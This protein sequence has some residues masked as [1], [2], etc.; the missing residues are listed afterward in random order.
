[1]TLTMLRPTWRSLRHA[2][3]FTITATLTLVVGIATIVAIFALIDG[4]LLRPLPY[5]RAEELVAAWHDLRGGSLLRTDQTGGTYF[6]Y[7]RFAHSIQGIGAYQ[8]GAANVSAVGGDAEPRRVGTTWISASILPVLAI[9]PMLGRGFTDDEDRPNGADAAI[10]GE[11]LWRSQY[12]A[13]PG[14]L[15]RSIQVNGRSRRIVGVM[16]RG[17]RFPSSETQVWLPLQLVPNDVEGFSYDAI[18]RLKPGMSVLAAQRDFAAVLPRVVEVSPMLAPGVSTQMLFDQAKPVP[19]LIPLKEDIT[20]GVAKT[21]WLVGAGACVLLLVAC[22]NVTNLV[23]VRADARQRE[24]AVREALGAGRVRV[25]AYLL[26]ESAMIATFAGVVAVGLAALAIHVVASTGPTEI[27]RLAEVRIDITT[28]AFAIGIAIM[29]AVLCSVIP[30][31]RVGRAHLADALRDAGRGATA[32]RLQLRLRHSLVALQMALALVALAAS[33]LLVR[34]FQRLNAIRPGFNPGSVL[35]LWVSLPTARYPNDTVVVAFYSR[36]LDRV[37]GLPGVRAASI[38][39]RVPLVDHGRNQNPFYPEDDPSFER[40]IPPVQLYATVDGEYFRAM[41]IPLLAGRTF[42]RL[43]TQRNDEA[44]ISQATA[45]QF[46]HDSTGQR[47]LGKRFRELPQA[48]WNT[49][50][51]VVGSIRDTAL[52]SGAA[53]AV[54]FAEV[55]SGDR[56]PPQ[57]RNTMALVVRTSIEPISLVKVIQRAVRELDP[58]LPIFDVRTMPAILKASM[59]QLSFTILVL[60]AAAVATL[61]LGVIG[62]Y[63]VMAYVVALRRREVGLRIALGASPRGVAL[64]LTRQGVVLTAFGIAGGLVLFTL[65]ARFM[66][67]LLYGVAPADPLTLVGAALLLVSIGTVASWIPAR[68]S[69][70]LDPAEVLRAD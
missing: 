45:V 48:P 24:L 9:A 38:T 51:G 40:R 23:L 5:P 41:G 53:Q 39:S 29:V 44:I 54:Y 4:V 37:R 7:K 6:T 10:I 12:A 26:G 63:G 60:G 34:T 20:A 33:G 58:T 2:P 8:E 61:I 11:G 49:V 21:L 42:D 35:T 19:L 15:G 30:A 13:D 68:R 46:W 17:F 55:P 65:A 69:A 32:G 27:P 59:A 56:F 3:A 31:L 67:T 16:P 14:I 70:R 50:I 52:A 66:R 22:A 57:T 64:M 1:M 47:A 62:L 28:I 25:L 43:E 36:L 18:A